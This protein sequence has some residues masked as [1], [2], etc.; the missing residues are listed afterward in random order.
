M[1]SPKHFGLTLTDERPVLARLVEAVATRRCL[2]V[3]DNC[4]QVLDA[5]GDLVDELLGACSAAQVVAT[6]REPLGVAGEQMWR[7]PTLGLDG[8]DA[9]SEAAKLFVERARLVDVRFMPSSGQWLLIES[10]CRRLDGLPLAIELAAAHVASL[11]VE[12]VARGVDNMFS[13]PV[14]GR[15]RAGRQATLRASILWSYDLLA[16]LERRLLPAL[17]VFAGGFTLDAAQGVGADDIVPVDAIAAVLVHLVDQSLVVADHQAAG[18][19]YRLLDTVRSFA[20]EELAAAGR[21]DEVRDRHLGWYAR[22][23]YSQATA[24]AELD[25][26]RVLARLR[27]TTSVTPRNGRSTVT[28]PTP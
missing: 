25:R 1:R 8:G 4:E 15:R 27:S 14:G 3:L 7:V 12:E 6:S 5:A 13:V 22:W 20:A 24:H 16:P 18:T 11:G 10:V 26:P 23:S 9:A 17:S 21:G 28:D 2:V 19:R